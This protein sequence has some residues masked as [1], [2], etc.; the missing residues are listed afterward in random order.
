MQG[1][2]N[3]DSLLPSVNIP[4]HTQ[5][6]AP[7]RRPSGRSIERTRQGFYCVQKHTSTWQPQSAA[8]QVP[9]PSPHDSSVDG[10][11][12]DWG[13]AS[14]QSPPRVQDCRLQM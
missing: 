12:A 7:W 1:S 9:A 2:R 5:Y 3:I 14:G 11:M 10:L 4:Q 6:H 8:P 13:F